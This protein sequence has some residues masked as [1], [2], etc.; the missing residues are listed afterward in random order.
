MNSDNKKSM[1]VFLTVLLFAALLPIARAQ[2]HVVSAKE[3]INM[4]DSIGLKFEMPG[5][6]Q[7]SAVIENDDLFYSFAMKHKNSDFEVRYS[8]FPMKQ[9][10]AEYELCKVTPGCA[11]VHPNNLFQAI[12]QANVLNMTA[13]KGASIGPFPKDA[14]KAEFNADA[15]G[16]AFFEF[17]C[18]FGKGYKYGQM[19]VLQ[20]DGVAEVIITFMSNDKSKHSELMFE[21]FHSLTFK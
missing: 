19:V 21:A 9:K 15:G 7:E 1:K 17:N 12:A 3:F 4:I 8:I 10:L 5:N 20:K 13:G 11:M 18:D 2:N 16:S 6:Y 14:V